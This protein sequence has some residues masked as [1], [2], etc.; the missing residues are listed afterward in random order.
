MMHLVEILL[1]LTD[2]E[3]Q[4]F[5]PS[6]FA[7]VRQ[8]LTDTFGGVTTFTRAPVH[9]TNVAAGEVQHDDIVIMEVMTGA[10]DKEWW[11]TYRRKLEADF[12]QDEI[13]I[14]AS[15]FDKL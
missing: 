7:A 15:V 10:I 9:G 11:D 13:V 6:K 14:R 8:N 5:S 3:G 4:A 12:A 2:N 1:P